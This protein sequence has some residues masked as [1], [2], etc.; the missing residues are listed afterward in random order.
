MTK[1]NA[2]IKLKELQTSGPSEE[3]HMIADDILCKLLITLGCREVVK[4][5]SKLDKWYA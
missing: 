3:S 1:E 4:E 5:Y 2:V